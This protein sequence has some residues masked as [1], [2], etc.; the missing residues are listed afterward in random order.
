MK[1]L[2]GSVGD[3]RCWI[4][5]TALKTSFVLISYEGDV[6]LPMAG[7]ESAHSC[8]SV[9]P[10]FF[11]G[12]ADRLPVVVRFPAGPQ[13]SLKCGDQSK[14]N[15]ADHKKNAVCILILAP[16]TVCSIL[17]GETIEVRHG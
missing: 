15:G 1:G 5:A 3:G 2:S 8:C 9:Y 12:D 14:D 7:S 4:A 11:L 10:G 16:C 6:F 13:E 17:H